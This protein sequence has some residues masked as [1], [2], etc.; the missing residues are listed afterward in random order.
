MRLDSLTLEYD[1]HSDL[2]AASLVACLAGVTAQ[3]FLSD[4][5]DDEPEGSSAALLELTVGSVTQILPSTRPCH[6][7]LGVASH[8]G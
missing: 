6:L 3:V 8:L 1:L 4:A 7:W 5:V 2:P